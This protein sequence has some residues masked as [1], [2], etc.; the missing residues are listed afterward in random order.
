[1]AFVA[2]S[3]LFPRRWHLGG[4]LLAIILAGYGA[5]TRLR[6]P[7]PSPPL[8]TA[9]STTLAQEVQFTGRVK[10][11][12]EAEL[13]LNYSGT[14]TRLDVEIGKRVEAG[15]VLLSIDAR[16][17]ALALAESKATLASALS[18]ARLAL[19]QA[20]ESLRLVQ[21]NNKAIIA[22]RKQTVRDTKKQLDAT[23]EWYRRVAAEE[24]DESALAQSALVSVRQAEAAF[25]A[26]QKTL[27]ST[28]ADARHQE[29]KA[30]AAVAQA[31]NELAA[32][33]RA[34]EDVAGPSALRARALTAAT[35]LQK[36]TLRA[37]FAG[38]ITKIT[39]EEGEFATAGVPLIKIETTDWLE[40]VADVPETDAV[41]LVPG[42]SAEISFDAL[43]GLRLR[44][45]VH[46]IYPAAREIEGVPTFSVVLS[47]LEKDKRVRIGL[48]AD[49]KVQ[50]AIRKNVV[51]IPQSAVRRE[52]KQVFVYLMTPQGKIKKRAVV[53][54]IRGAEGKV[55][56]VRGLRE[57]EQ[58][59]APASQAEAWLKRHR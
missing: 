25:H 45:N 47:L 37:P 56:I 44:G 2:L 30:R 51:V 23:R 31:R 36:H 22:E 34:A 14:I 33:E 20:E 57:G 16:E 11:V 42:Q 49:I 43:P 53:L 48:T 58:V 13:A 19:R 28:E 3:S 10:A 55:E 12:R 21:Q 50:T 17:A 18:T 46:Q 32:L 40:V 15:Q 4:L 35:Q 41:K 29:E 5:W 52:G 1:M 7:Q 27:T 24:G 59:I 54:G 39:K 8:F 6:A 38:V 9:T 26:A